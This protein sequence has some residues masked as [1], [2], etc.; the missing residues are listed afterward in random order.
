MKKRDIAILIGLGTV[1]LIAAWYFL[2]I[3]PKRDDLEKTQADIKNEQ[4]KLQENERRLKQI[5]Q[6]RQ[7]ARQTD[8]DL[9]KLNKL[10]PV[11][12]QVES[13]IVEL[14]QSANESGIW[15]MNI[16][17]AAPVTGVGGLTVVPIEVK[18][19][20]SFFDLNDF[21]YRVENYAR[22]DGSDI[23]VSGRLVNV[24]TLKIQE[25]DVSGKKFPY[26]DATG[27]VFPGHALIILNL[28]VYMTSPPPPTKKAG[29]GGAPSTGTATTP[30][31]STTGTS[32][33]GAGGESAS[34]SPAASAAGG[35]A[36]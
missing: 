36:R 14:Q 1:V 20:G 4:A 6:E 2:I 13:L 3:S 33:A 28:N 10:V 5:D 25:P 23:N 17:P 30:T 19:E 27:R 31:T 15:F 32:A 22:M 26:V 18:F 16:K 29:A 34:A 24:V 9:L 11:D 7:T 21:L 12:D 8:S 35:G